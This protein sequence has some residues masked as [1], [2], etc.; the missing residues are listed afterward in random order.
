M[1]ISRG[2][3]TLTR[4][5][6]VHLL[7]TAVFGHIG[8]TV[9]A[10]PMIVPARFVV[11]A[12]RIVIP[13]SSSSEV[14]HASQSS[15]VAFEANDVNTH[16]GEGWSVLVVGRARVVEE[17]PEF[18]RLARLANLMWVTAPE[19]RYIVIALDMVSGRRFGETGDLAEIA[20][21]SAN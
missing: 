12:G 4:D 16:T 1:P 3:E 5:E 8:I 7:R 2:Q 10:L 11:D 21:P 6:C 20:R 14:L 18:D 13:V 9:R 19:T 15:I 17:G